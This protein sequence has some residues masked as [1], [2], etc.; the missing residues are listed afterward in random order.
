[1]NPRGESV[2]GK[3]HVLSLVDGLTGGAERFAQLITIHL[4]SERFRRTL[5]VTRDYE[6]LEEAPVRGQ[7]QEAGATLL[8]LGRRHRADLTPWA[9]LL[10]YLR[11]ESVDV[12]HAHKFGSNVWASLL[13][14]P[15]RTPVAIAHEHTW[16]YE[17]QPVRRF[18][19]RAL[20]STRCDR[21]IAVSQL[22]RRR[23]IQIE[24]I[25]PQR[26]EIVPVGIPPRPMMGH[27]VRE[28]LEIPV[29]APVVTAVG[30]LRPQK[31]FE[32]LLEATAVLRPSMPSLRV[33]MVGDG[34]ERTKLEGLIDSLN[35]RDSATILGV[36]RDVMDVLAASD[37][38]VCCS[39]FEGSP[40][41]VIEYMAAG[42]PVVATRVGG[43]PDL[44]EDGVTGVLVEPRSPTHLARAIGD[45]LAR[46][47]RATE[48]GARGKERQRS[49][50]TIDVTLARLEA[51]YHQLLEAC[52]TRPAS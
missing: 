27:D 29:G 47:E 21:M 13:R 48:M 42:K 14:G 41:A 12:L 35:L 43:L 9:K 32:V 17:G 49:E 28:E 26:I 51:L 4:D 19:D 31:A 23:M 8:M 7:L 30:H 46:P 5:C 34:P 18:L 38:A 50:F 22:D 45:L 52:E 39:D 20:I 11:S 44:V 36:R 24:R 40:Q 16:S 10:R 1:M 25:D 37:I 2:R 15:A 33:L 3:P 6:P